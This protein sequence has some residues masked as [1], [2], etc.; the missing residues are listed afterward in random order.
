[1][2]SVDSSI[3]DAGVPKLPPMEMVPIPSPFRHCSVMAPKLLRSANEPRTFSDS[4]FDSVRT[5][6]ATF[7]S[8]SMLT[9]PDW[10]PCW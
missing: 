9:V 6:A 8:T 10:D 1:M 7:P 4:I 2:K 5:V 3:E